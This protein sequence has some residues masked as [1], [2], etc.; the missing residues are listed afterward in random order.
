L[1][2]EYYR[3]RVGAGLIIA[4]ATY[5]SRQGRGYS[6]VPGI[7]TDEQEAAWKQLVDAVHTEGGRIALQLWHAGRVSHRTLQAGD[8]PPIAP[9]TIRAKT[10]KVFVVGADD[11]GEMVPADQPRALETSEI[12]EI[13][14]Q[15]VRAAERC[16]RVG[17]DMIEIHGAN[18]YL[19]HQFL[20][21]NTN[22]R[23][24]RY[25]GSIENRARLTVE[26]MEAV[27]SVFSH[28][29]VGLRLSPNFTGQD[30]ADTES[31]AASM[32]VA[33]ELSRLRV[34][35]LHIAEP[36]WLGGNALSTTFRRR[37]RETFS[38]AVVVCGSYTAETAEERIAQG[39]AD[40]VAFGRPFIANPDLVERFRRNA[41][42]N[43]ADRA[44]YYGG[45]GRGYTDYP[46][47]APLDGW[48]NPTDV[49]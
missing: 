8:A 16:R 27:C 37:L 24:D 9:S 48:K 45:D 15:Y 1:N 29:R 10:T 13:V 28:D 23:T 12:P 3:Q 7:C 11:K 41:P 20:S 46:T 40:A 44:T 35:Y 22:M 25:G 4:E 31:E 33:R 32:I 5:I 34:G 39:H 18:G 19:L 38:G 2:I 30:M 43:Q 49:A 42:L 21:T 6:C 14:E 47:L 17:F 26:V 36:D